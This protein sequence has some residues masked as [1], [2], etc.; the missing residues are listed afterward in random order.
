M[1]KQTS[2]CKQFAVD[3][4]VCIK[5]AFDA[6]WIELARRGIER[7]MS[8]PGPFFRNLGDGANSAFSD[9]W[10]R[11]HIP[12]F[13][14]FCMESPAAGIAALA[15]QSP[16]VHLAQDTWF[17]KQPGSSERTPWHHDT[18]LTGPFCSVWV[19]LDPTPRAATLEF[20]RGSHLCGQSLMPQSFFDAK[21]ASA[22]DAFY[23]EF[24]GDTT[25]A[26][27]HKF[28]KLPDIE[29]DRDAYDIIGWEM[30]P[31]DCVVF[32]ARTIHGAPGNHLAHP[33]RRFITR[34]VT[35][36]TVVS[37]HGRRMV[38]MLGNLG[39][40]LEVGKPLNDPLFPEFTGLSLSERDR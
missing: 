37:E 28:G 40:K 21:N 16:R 14:R 24:H 4:A 10:S 27:A 7:N 3:G 26:D 35:R 38:D 15:L 19:A 32:D 12:E 6:E 20:V 39:I 31:G 13:N 23:A 34:W 17:L 11:R 1:D 33:V 22:S 25:R 9:M 2:W 8:D 30:A 5:N 29:S 36:E 18:V